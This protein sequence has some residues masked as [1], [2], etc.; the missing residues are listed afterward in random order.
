MGR[1]KIA[2]PESP[3]LASVS[4][5]IRI[6]DLN[7]GAHLGNDRLLLYAHEARL[8]MLAQ[9]GWTEMH[10]AGHALIMADAE[11]AFRAEGFYGDIL[12]IA[13]QTGEGTPKSFSLFY[14]FTKEHEGKSIEVAHIRTGMAAFDYTA[15]KTVP[16]SPQLKEKL[17]L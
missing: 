15:R 5:P 7:Y 17:G 6:G 3:V 14:R 4:L 13:I 2:F 11:I 16:L 8:Q 12:Q 1:V 9:W 10:C